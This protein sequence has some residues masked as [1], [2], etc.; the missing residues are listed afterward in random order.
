MIWAAIL[1]NSRLEVTFLE[2]NV[3]AK[4]NPLFCAFLYKS[5]G[6]KSHHDMETRLDIHAR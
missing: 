4:E 6:R 3:E 5:F 2:R 1:D